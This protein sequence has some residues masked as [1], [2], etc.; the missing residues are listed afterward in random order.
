MLLA[1]DRTSAGSRQKDVPL[2][3]QLQ[4][5]SASEYG[6][7]IWHGG[8]SVRFGRSSQLTGDIGGGGDGGGGNGGGAFIGRDAPEKRK[9]RP[10]M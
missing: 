6:V 4:F 3:P 9:L 1:P 10:F 5:S 7:T 2:T 8:S